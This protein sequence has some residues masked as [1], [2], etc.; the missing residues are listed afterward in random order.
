MSRDDIPNGSRRDP[1]ALPAYLEEREGWAFGY[2]PQPRTH[3][4]ARFFAGGVAAVTGVDPLDRFSSQWTTRRG[5]RRVLAK[6]GGMAKA[7]GEVMTEIEPNLAQ[8]GDGGLTDDRTLVLVEGDTV[9]GLDPERG[10]VRLPRSAMTR[11][12]TI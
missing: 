2:G 3:E 4:C 6:H 12:W 5:A 10:Y 1:N 8:R 7:L 11:A 9:V